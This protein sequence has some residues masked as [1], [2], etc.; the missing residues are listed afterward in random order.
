MTRPLLIPKRKSYIV[1]P[2]TVLNPMSL[3]TTHAYATCIKEKVSVVINNIL[4]KAV[5]GL[6]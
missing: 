1:T 6:Q 2:E 4:M 5:E 3:H